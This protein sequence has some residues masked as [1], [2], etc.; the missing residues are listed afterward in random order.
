V[1]TKKSII[2]QIEITRTGHIQVRFGLLLLEGDAEIDKKWHR[3]SIEPGGDVDMQMAAVNTNLIQ[4]GK[5]PV[6]VSEIARVKVLAHAAWT[7]GVLA[8]ANR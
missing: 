5:E 8:D 1:I 2:D 3:T 4:M 7:P 6:S